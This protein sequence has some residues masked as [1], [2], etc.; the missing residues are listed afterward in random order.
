MIGRRDIAA[1]ADWA[2]RQW[3]ARRGEAGDIGADL[4]SHEA[5][6]RAQTLAHLNQVYSLPYETLAG[7][8]AT[9]RAQ[10]EQHGK[11][12]V[13][14]VTSGRSGMKWVYEIFRAHA[15]ATGG[16]ERNVEAEAF[17]R[18]AKFNGLP[19]DM[20]GV[21]AVTRREIMRDWREADI[22][23]TVSPYFSHDL[24]DLFFRLG[25]RRVIWGITDP[26]FTATSCFNKGLYLRDILLADHGLAVGYQPDARE[27]W[28]H[29]FGRL[30]PRGEHFGSWRQLTRVGKIG[31]FLNTL[32]LEIFRQVQALPKD[33]V[34]VFRLE[35]AD[36]N[37]GYYRRLARAFGLRPV[38]SEPAFLAL[39]GK[40]ATA[41][42][43]L[44]REWSATERTE[45]EREA[46]DYIEL[47]RG[48]AL[49][50]PGF[51]SSGI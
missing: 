5:A 9:Y 13:I 3:L 7:A 44:R 49:D 33:T 1:L 4:A 21:L 39:K 28:S 51:L 22:S 43:N 37:Y 25:A 16:G 27:S 2:A 20:A 47:Y 50:D 24:A 15:N 6:I 29:F 19:V 11:E 36:Q 40:A 8:E 48:G 30:V 35:Q 26:E 38:L 17:Y 10:L 31:W 34:W 42:E 18:W 32:H 46:A 14:G 23:L 12:L 41:G 45:F